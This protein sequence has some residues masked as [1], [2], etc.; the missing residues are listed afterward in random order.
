MSSG[1]Q[2]ANLGVAGDGVSPLENKPELI[3]W[4]LFLLLYSYFLKGVHE[5]LEPKTEYL[6]D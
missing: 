5:S 2:E 6:S 1:L 4:G 3:Y